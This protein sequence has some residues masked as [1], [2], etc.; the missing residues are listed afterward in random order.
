MTVSAA[1]MDMTNEISDKDRIQVYEII[2]LKHVNGLWLLD[3]INKR[4]VFIRL[5]FVTT[6]EANTNYSDGQMTADKV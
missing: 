4:T 3:K 1:C 5:K 6:G 2:L